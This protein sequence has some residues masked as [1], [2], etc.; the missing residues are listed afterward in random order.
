M[1]N[2]NPSIFL[3]VPD[4]VVGD[5]TN[6]GCALALIV[7]DAYVAGR[8]FCVYLDSFAA[9]AS[10]SSLTSST[11]AALDRHEADRSIPRVCRSVPPPAGNV[12][13]TYRQ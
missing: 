4:S 8:P 9:S 12:P 3:V 1:S 5:F 13:A 2:D 10:V 6:I 7:L 11:M